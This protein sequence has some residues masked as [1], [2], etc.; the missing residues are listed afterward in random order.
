LIVAAG[1]LLARQVARS[2]FDLRA[3]LQSLSG[4]SWGWF[5]LGC[6]AA[7]STF[8]L[9]AL[10]WAVFL[11]PLT[12][13]PNVWRLTKATAIGFTAIT[14]LGRP[15]EFVRPWLIA[16]NERVSFPSQ[17]AALVLE[18][19]FDL[20]AA[21]LIFGAGLVQVDRAGVTAGPSLAWVLEAGG[22][23]VLLLVGICVAILVISKY[24]SNHVRAAGLWLA[25]RLPGVRHRAA[26]LVD[27]ALKGIQSTQSA[28]ALL[29]IGI[30]TLLEWLLI[31]G[32]IA[33]I[34]RAFGAS[35][36]LGITDMVIF[37]GFLAFG[38]VVQ[39]PGVGGGIQVVTVLVLTELFGVG[40]ELATGVAV[41]LWIT[42][43]V[44]IVPFG[45]LLA[46]Q[47]GLRWSALAHVKEE[48]V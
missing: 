10:R 18:R 15:G 35:I 5:L 42:S 7:L 45:L 26:A 22:R 32:N 37:T 39:I 41:M 31:L 9:R 25:H 36:D 44:I 2:G 6:A 46:L 4:L 38:A 16:R 43:F 12:P 11:E 1:V 47:D 29:R 20:L 23:L 17:L 21:L 48:V 24:Y 13:E 33:L 3:F 27:A 8:Y 30:Y 34:F 14:L 40:L 28:G 19:L